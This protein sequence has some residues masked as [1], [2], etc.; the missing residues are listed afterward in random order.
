MILIYNIIGIEF[1]FSQTIY[2]MKC[3]LTTLSSIIRLK[4]K[5]LELE[6]LEIFL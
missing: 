1:E 4:L 3:S 6:G 5:Y 2:P